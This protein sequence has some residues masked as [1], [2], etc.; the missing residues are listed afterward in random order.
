LSYPLFS[1][2][3]W[4]SF[5]ALQSTYVFFV[6]STLA[7]HSSTLKREKTIPQVSATFFVIM[8]ATREDFQN[9]KYKLVNLTMVL[10]Q[11]QDLWP[12]QY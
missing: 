4:E 6:S 11:G 3:K 1:L 2:K 8:L 12:E 10:P 9:T 7:P 5:S